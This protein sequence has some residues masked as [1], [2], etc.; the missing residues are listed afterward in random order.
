[1][2]ASIFSSLDIQM[3]HNEKQSYENMQGVL[4]QLLEVRTQQMKI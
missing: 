3:P 1:M 2:A 4:E